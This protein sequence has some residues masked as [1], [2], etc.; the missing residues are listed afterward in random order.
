MAALTAREL[1]S[2]VSPVPA[3]A[4]EPDGIDDALAV[5]P[6]L[7]RAALILHYM[8]RLSVRD[9]ARAIGKSEAAAASLLARGRDAFRQAY[10]EADPMND[11]RPFEQLAIARRTGRGR[12]GLRGSAYA[13]MQREIGRS[14][15]TM[16]PIL[17]LVA[18]LV[19]AVTITG[20]VVIGSGLVDPP[21]VN[22][23]LIPTASAAASAPSSRLRPRRRPGR[24][25]TGSPP[26]A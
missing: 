18:A 3:G 11:E 5:L 25:G 8:D 19:A 26:R 7:Q 10:Q 1:G 22:R 23:L 17:L 21:W 24:L 9:V 2:V 20:A 13:V 14:Q 4:A 15:R 16:G 6:A 12:R